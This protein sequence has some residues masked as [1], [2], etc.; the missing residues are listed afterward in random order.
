ME[1]V[2][3]HKSITTLKLITTNWN[4]NSIIRKYVFVGFSTRSD[5]Y[6]GTTIEDGCSENKNA[7]QLPIIAQLTCTFGFGYAKSKFSHDAVH[8][9]N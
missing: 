8:I 5:K 7:V 4:M 1:T 3:Y 9:V 6:G 2:L